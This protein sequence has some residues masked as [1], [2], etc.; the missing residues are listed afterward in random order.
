[1]VSVVCIWPSLEQGSKFWRG[2]PFK[3][4]C[5]SDPDRIDAIITAVR[6]LET[7]GATR[8][9]AIGNL[10]P[11]IASLP[12]VE[13]VGASQSNQFNSIIFWLKNLI[14]VIPGLYLRTLS[15]R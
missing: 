12:D 13:Q 4:H 2:R 7:V 9:L 6:R 3:A 14:I 5:P 10:I 11:R 8:I 1:M 15:Q